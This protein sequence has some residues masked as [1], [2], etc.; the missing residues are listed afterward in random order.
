MKTCVN[1]HLDLFSRRIP[2]CHRRPCYRHQHHH[3][4]LWIHSQYLVRLGLTSDPDCRY[5][6]R[7]RRTRKFRVFGRVSLVQT[8]E[9][10]YSSGIFDTKSSRPLRFLDMFRFYG[11]T[12]KRKADTAGKPPHV[13]RGSCSPRV[14]S[15]VCVRVRVR[16]R[17]IPMA[18]EKAQV[19]FMLAA[20]FLHLNRK[21]IGRRFPATVA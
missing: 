19:F 21:Q 13:D 3:N 20:D 18:H 9:T 7:S 8:R 16:V 4:K 2:P 14:C 17:S 6:C 11:H 5:T 12:E 10:R 15:C 1:L